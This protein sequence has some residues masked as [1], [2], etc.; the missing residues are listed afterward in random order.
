[1]N[2]T[3]KLSTL[4]EA[5]SAP[6]PELCFA[7]FER[8]TVIDVVRGGKGAY[9]GKTLEECRVEYPDAAEMTLEAFCV[10]KAER[11]RTPITWEPTTEERYWEMLE[12]LPPAAM[13]RG[14]FLVGEP[15]DHDAGSGEPRFEAYCQTGNRFTVSSRPI[16]RREFRALF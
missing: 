15:A 10:W 5:E 6:E 14:G 9:G 2:L 16:T 4:I 3:D 8:G 7:S 13:Y 11:Q 1:M 12:V